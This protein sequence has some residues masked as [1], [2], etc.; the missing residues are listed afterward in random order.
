MCLYCHRPPETVEP[1]LLYTYQGLKDTTKDAEPVEDH[2]P[3]SIHQEASNLHSDE[4]MEDII[5]LLDPRVQKLIRTYVEAFG[6]LPP[7]ASCD[8]LVKMDLKLKPEFVGHK[9]RRR[10][11]PAPK[12]Q[13]NEI[14]RQIQECIDDG[15]VVEYKDG[16]YPQHCSPC[17]LVAKL[18]T[19]A[20]R[21]IVDFGELNKKT[22]N[23]SGSIPN[24][25]STL[26]RIA[27]CR[28]KTKMDKRSGFWQVDLTPN[29]QEL[30]AFITR[31]VVAQSQQ[32]KNK[33]PR[34]GRTTRKNQAKNRLF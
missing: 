30:N 29:A 26:E 21:L 2:L 20:K 5:E 1:D 13:A 19:T 7:P 27:S 11:Y 23:H 15:L 31:R 28:Y 34:R 17:F 12:E 9:I 22:L 24:M 18:G 10:P 14:E 4:D 6:E 16:D 33:I 32:K 3:A 8:K 25:E